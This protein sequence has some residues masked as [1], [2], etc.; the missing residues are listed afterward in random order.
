MTMLVICSIWSDI[1]KISPILST[2]IVI[3]IFIISQLIAHYS[4]KSELRRSWYF[5]AYFDSSLTRVN[6][7]FKSCDDIIKKSLKKAIKIENLDNRQNYIAKKLE[8]ISDDQRQFTNQVLYPLKGAYP[9]VFSNLELVLESF[10][11]VHSNVFD[12][13]ELGDDAYQKYTSEV[14][15]I[16]NNLMTFLA[17]PVLK[18]KQSRILKAQIE[19]QN[20]LVSG[21]NYGKFFSLYIAGIVILVT[22]LVV[23]SYFYPKNNR[24]QTTKENL[25]K[26]VQYSV[27]YKLLSPSTAEFSND[28]KRH[29]KILEKNIFFVNS[30]VDSQN[31]YG[32]TIRR[33]FSCKI[34][35]DDKTDNYTLIDLKVNP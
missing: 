12:G 33:Y 31:I 30:Y 18:N 29:V 4:R 32:A 16:Q 14:A 13:L 8:K 24:F 25:L 1:V 23:F 3:I 34:I 26:Q 28:Y 2:S 10:Y 20:L 15:N 27:K 21:K 11:D 22:G 35:Y 7:F 19:S 9:E 5:K 17:I 6:E